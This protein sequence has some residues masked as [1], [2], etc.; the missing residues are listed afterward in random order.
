MNGQK[1]EKTEWT[2]V[3]ESLKIGINNA[4][5]QLALFRVQLAE[6]ETHVGGK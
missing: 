6:A 5:I 4:E 2:E 3:I 1:P